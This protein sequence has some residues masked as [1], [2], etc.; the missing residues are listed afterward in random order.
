[1]RSPT[2]AILW[3]I[4]ARN[5]YA[6]MFA[7]GAM[8]VCAVIVALTRWY[9][10]WANVPRHGDSGDAWQLVFAVSI[11]VLSALLSLTSIFW[12]FTFTHIDERGRYGGF[13]TRL[14]TLPVR[15]RDA[16]APPVLAGVAAV[17]LAFTVWAT[18][19]LFLLR[20]NGA[21]PWLRFGWQLVVLATAFVTIQAII[22]LLHP[23]RF[24]RMVVIS[25]AGIV[26]L[27]MFFW[28][29]EVEF[30]QRPSLFFA[31]GAAGFASAVMGAFAVVRWERRGGWQ[32]VSRIALA[33]IER[34]RKLFASAASAQ[35]W[36]ECRRK[37][38]FGAAIIGFAMALALLVW[39]VPQMLFTDSDEELRKVELSMMWIL[40]L[41]TLLITTAFGGAFGK[42]DPWGPEIV[43]SSFHAVRPMTTARL[44]FAKWIAAL[45][46]VL[47]A[48]LIFIASSLVIAV[49]RPGAGVFVGEYLPQFA[50]AHPALVSWITNPIVLL[51]MFFIQWHTVVA[52]M[53]VVLSGDSRRMMVAG[54]VGIG[55]L[56]AFVGTVVWFMKRPDHFAWWQPVLPWLAAVLVLFKVG[57]AIS[58]FAKARRG[59][60]SSKQFAVMLALWAALMAG[61][62][63]ST[64]LAVGFHAFPRELIWFVAVWLM[65]SGEMPAC[66][67]HFAM[68]RHR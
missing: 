42:S 46:M 68:N 67:I 29:P 20:E 25:I 49:A 37:L 45:Q 47:L 4:T 54:W 15:T 8:P 66:V 53:S 52:S 13:P 16:V 43:M 60:V 36:F 23:F 48:W 2:Q 3:E 18:L 32:N 12:A 11:T 21:L 56:S 44:V 55:I 58:V 40:P 1:M 17:T 57:C 61:V 35:L 27:W 65:P 50:A 33:Q 39:T 19:L 26:L 34:G 63:A 38:I 22:W 51:T 59:L 14:F 10:A 28:P 6:M 62:A 41:T 31:C 30:Y 5:R 24:A 9:L 64:F 7:F